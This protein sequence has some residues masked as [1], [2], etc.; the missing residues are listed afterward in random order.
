MNS[1]SIINDESRIFSS[2][3]E[4]HVFVNQN[5]EIT[6]KQ[7]TKLQDDSLIFIPVHHVGKLISA[8]KN[9]KRDILS[10]EE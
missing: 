2:C 1:K 7:I 3:E 6:I 4:T 5:N 8:L 9:A 10:L